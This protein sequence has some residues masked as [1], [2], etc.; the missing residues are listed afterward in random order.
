V[1]RSRAAVRRAAARYAAAPYLAG[2]SPRFVYFGGGTPSYLSTEQLRTLFDGLRARL[3]WDDVEELAFEA[4]PG[5]L[6]EG[7]AR[8]LAELGVTRL[9]F[10]VENF[11]PEILE[12]NNRAHGAVEIDRAYGWARA[13]GFPQINVDLIAGMVGETEDNWW[14]CIERVIE[15]A[16]ESVTIYQMEVP[17]NTELYQRMKA[18]GS[19]APV[20][21]WETKRRWTLGGF[22]RLE[23]AGY[24]VGSAYTAYRGDGIA[25][26]YRDALWQGA[27]M[28]GLGVS[29]FGHLGGVHYQNEHDYEPYVSRAEAGELPL[30]RAL[31]LSDEERLIR[32]FVLQ[33]KLGQLDPA[34]FQDKFGVDVLR[35]FAEPLRKHQADGYLMAS[36]D[37]IRL[38][39]DGLMRVDSLLPAFFLA[40][41][42]G[43]RYA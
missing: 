36:A 5:T 15:M 20:A 24:V 39:R 16:P 35:R 18:D 4:E 32:E 25:F 28:I 33:L 30:H 13:A 23:A 43:S 29:A 22:E 27:D 42:R 26:L 11:D 10:G 9:S 12:L 2:R 14:R 40:E 3:A 37:G 17:Y 21:D 6:Q 8:L 38:T 31:A 19:P 41:H 34:W 1:R 7:K